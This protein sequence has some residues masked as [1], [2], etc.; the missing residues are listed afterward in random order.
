MKLVHHNKEQ[1]LIK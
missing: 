1:A